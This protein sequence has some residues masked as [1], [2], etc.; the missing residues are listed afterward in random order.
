MSDSRGVRGGNVQA[1]VR[2]FAGVALLAL[3]HGSLLAQSPDT[4][5]PVSLARRIS[6]T[7][8]QAPI[9]AVLAAFAAFSGASIVAGRGV[10]SA[11]TLVV[12]DAASAQRSGAALLH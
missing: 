12:S 3:L 9:R 11:N 4:P 10:G 7:W 2:I 6:V 1:R 8:K 5:T